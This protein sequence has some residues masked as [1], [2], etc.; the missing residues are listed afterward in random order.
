MRHCLKNEEVG[1]G[2]KEQRKASC[3]GSGSIV[4]GFVGTG[5]SG[6]KGRKEG[7]MLGREGENLEVVRCEILERKTDLCFWQKA[8]ELGLA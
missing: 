1:E 6:R 4:F 7:W 5:R 3:R 8:P 2:K